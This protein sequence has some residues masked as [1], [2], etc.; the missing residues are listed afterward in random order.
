M[1]GVE[2]REY[3]YLEVQARVLD[4][5]GASKVIS[6]WVDGVPQSVGPG[7]DVSA[8]LTYAGSFGYRV[9]ARESQ[10]NGVHRDMYFSLERVVGNTPRG[11]IALMALER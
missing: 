6:L 11:E 3:E 7:D 10:E 4:R 5:V 8:F 2:Q 1:M 9:V